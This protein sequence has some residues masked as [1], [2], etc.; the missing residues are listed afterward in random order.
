MP[1]Y[2][3]LSQSI[4]TRAE[5]N[6]D[7]IIISRKNFRKKVFVFFFLSNAW[8]SLYSNR[9]KNIFDQT[10]LGGLWGGC[11]FIREKPELKVPG[12][13]VIQFPVIFF[14]IGFSR[15]AFQG[16]LIS[17]TKTLLSLKIE[18]LRNFSI[19]Y[20]S[21]VWKIGGK[22]HS[23]DLNSF[24]LKSLFSS[25]HWILQTFNV[26]ILLRSI[27]KKQISPVQAGDFPD[28]L[29]SEAPHFYPGRFL[30]RFPGQRKSGT[31]FSIFRTG[32]DGS[33][34]SVTPD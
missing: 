1:L 9:M 5:R 12:V 15:F 34:Y 20:Y 8:L 17:N 30:Q 25:F 31:N 6:A 2:S 16:K 28:F 21:Q 24:A 14:L 32:E 11:L 4:R 27:G 7:R 22:L 19:H 33:S 29:S 10:L 13:Y 26:G 18:V 3:A 23:K